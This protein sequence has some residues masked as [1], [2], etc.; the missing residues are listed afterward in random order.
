MDWL[1]GLR[2]LGVKKKGVLVFRLHPSY[3]MPVLHLGLY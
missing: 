2:S 3:Q 1:V